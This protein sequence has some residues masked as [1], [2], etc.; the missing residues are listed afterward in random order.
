MDK[1]EEGRWDER[2]E[3]R[4]GR[5]Q[6][7]ACDLYTC[8]SYSGSLTVHPPGKRHLRKSLSSSRDKC[9]IYTIALLLICLCL[10]DFEEENYYSSILADKKSRMRFSGVSDS[11]TTPT[12]VKKTISKR[13]TIDVWWLSDDGGLTLLVPYLL[14]RKRSHLEGAYL[15]IFTIAADGVS[16]SSEEERMASLLQKFRIQYKHLHVVAAIKEPRK[17]MYVGQCKD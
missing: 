2:Q 4:M 3:K 15:R 8:T 6:T 10:S 14:T 13:A 17:E 16:I 11:S 7:Y 5:R 12:T 9:V 1:R